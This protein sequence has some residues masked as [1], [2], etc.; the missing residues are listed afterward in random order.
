MRASTYIEYNTT[1]G[2]SSLGVRKLGIGLGLGS[3]GRVSNAV[4]IIEA[5]KGHLLQ[6][7]Q[8]NHSF[9]VTDCFY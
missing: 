7:V 4:V 2:R 5:T 8:L 9:N 3:Q 1:D 6:I